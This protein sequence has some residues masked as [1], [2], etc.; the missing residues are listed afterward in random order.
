MASRRPPPPKPERP[1]LSIAQ[2]LHGV[3]ELEARIK[4]LQEF[5]PSTVRERFKD[6]RVEVLETAI[7][8]TLSDVFGH[9]TTEYDR[10]NG[11]LNLD[12][13]PVSM[14]GW[15]EDGRSDAHMAQQYLNEGKERATALLTKAKQR[16]E[17]EIERER[18]LG[19]GPVEVEQSKVVHSRKIFIVHGHDE[20]MREA[21]ARF[22]AHISFDPIILHE[23][24]IKDERSSR[25]LKITAGASASP[26]FFSRRM[27]REM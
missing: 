16:L 8:E 14:G 18:E 1:Q 23:Q 17:N 10:Y 11:A 5:D 7:D 13:G 9:R 20:A 26:S 25:K 15:G 6:S 3:R 19:L 21:V 4:E 2:K 27:M 12:T 24:A 22:I